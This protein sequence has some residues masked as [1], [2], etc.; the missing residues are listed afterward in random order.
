MSSVLLMMFWIIAT[1][2]E[3]CR[4]MKPDAISL[5]ATSTTILTAE[6]SA[7][8]ACTESQDLDFQSDLP[9]NHAQNM[10]I[11][12]RLI[13]PMEGSGTYSAHM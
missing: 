13:G 12:K 3:S 9:A 5:D 6:A 4:L 8:Q 11:V 7:S 1:W 10:A 2:Q